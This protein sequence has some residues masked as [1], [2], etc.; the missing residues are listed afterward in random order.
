MEPGELP[1]DPDCISDVS[2]Q[3]S[4][5]SV[6]S[7][8]IPKAIRDKVTMKLKKKA[9]T[10]APDSDESDEDLYQVDLDRAFDYYEVMT[11]QE[12]LRAV[13]ARADALKKKY[14]E[15][16]DLLASLLQEAQIPPVKIDSG[17]IPELSDEDDD[18][19]SDYPQSEA[20]ETSDY[21][22]S[23]TAADSNTDVANTDCTTDASEKFLK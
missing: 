16:H 8:E 15:Q 6:S 3:L 20:I 22:Q 7:S 9:P 5:A 21:P 13:K 14:Y 12:K 18:D 11:P 2:S 4:N 19:S 23:E 1:K 10:A 17:A